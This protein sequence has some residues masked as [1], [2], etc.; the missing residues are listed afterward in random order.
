MTREQLVTSMRTVQATALE[1]RDSCLACVSRLMR[2]ALG[3][4][5]QSCRV[6]DFLLAWHNAQENRGWDPTDLWNVDA[7]IADDILIALHLLRRENRYP[8]DLGFQKE[9]HQIWQLWRASEGS[10]Q[11][12]S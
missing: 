10:G 1:D 12:K 7:A 6:A 8:A 3:N 5:G 9:I 4:T 11:S 2:I